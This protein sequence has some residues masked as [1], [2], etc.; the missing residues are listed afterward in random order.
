MIYYLHQNWE[1]RMNIIKEFE[2]YIVEWCEK[3]NKPLFKADEKVIDCVK[4]ITIPY[5]K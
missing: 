5:G 3:N 2:S 1:H 4:T